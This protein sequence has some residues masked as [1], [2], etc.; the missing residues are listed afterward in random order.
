A[1]LEYAVSV[2]KGRAL[3]EVCDGQ[4][5]V[6]RRILY[7]MHEMGLGPNTKPVKSARV[8]GDVI[9]KFHPHGDTAAYE[10]MVRMAQDFVMRYPLV[11]G[12]G[13][14]GS[15][16]GDGA[17]AM[18]YTEARLTPLA[19]L[20]LSEI[21]KGTVDFIANYDG[22][23]QEPKMLPSRLP[24]VLLN[25]ASGIAVGMAT[26]IPSHNL[27]EI[28]SA[29]VALIRN[30]EMTVAELMEHVPGP[31][32]PGGAQII[33]S[34][35]EIQQAYETG[36]S[37]LKVRARW[38]V[39]ELARGQWQVVVTELPPNTSAAHVLEEIEEL[40]NPKVKAGKKTLTHDQNQTK[41]LI[42]DVLDTAR[43]ESGKDTP[44]RL[45]FEPKSSRKDRNEF[46]TTLLAHTS[47][48][49]SVP[50]NMVMIGL[51]GRPRQK[52]LKDV[53]T[54]WID[55]RFETV[56]RRSQH[57]LNQVLDRIHVLE[58][59]QIVF[60]N[61]DAVIK[62]IREADDPKADLMAKFK[63]SE[64]QAEDILEIRLR[65]L[66]RLEGIKIE[67]ELSELRGEQSELELLLASPQALQAQVVKEIKADAKQF[68]DD[69]RTL[70]EETQRAVLTVNVVNEPLTIVLSDKGWIR[71]R[72]GHSLDLS[73]LSFKEGD[74]LSTSMEC[75]SV[76]NCIVFASDGRVYSIPAGQIPG[77]RGDGVPVTTFIELQPKARI[78]QMV[79]GRAEQAL[80]LATSGGYGFMCKLG[81]LTSRNRAGKQF[82]TVEEGETVLKPVLYTEDPEL[83]LAAVS[84]HGRMHCFPLN[85]MKALSGGGRGVIV[86][87]LDDHEAMVALTTYKTAV[88]V[89]GAIGRSTKPFVIRLEGAK[90][91]DY[92]GKRARKGRLIDARLKLVALLG[93]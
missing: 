71:S 81:D 37:S 88:E 11:D 75:R 74:Q 58:G 82:I 14:F 6:Q 3:P 8:V 62:T 21:D 16:D 23:Q 61:L 20:L 89:H 53:L 65:Q 51:D 54:E 45:V 33:S 86:M 87:G 29:A 25:G 34:P 91:V 84:E 17:A 67:Q 48:E 27:R 38:K 68:G 18:R 39:E 22:S 66:A 28:A 60:L 52:P 79:A 35:A 46:I 50:I 24:M 90:L 12:Q 36:R 73:Q 15:R 63:L 49:T 31:D 70:I 5:P 44:V 47:L 41:A 92:V 57:R 42:L 69:R 55:F 85:E 64:R 32:F 93:F 10:A 77:G 4:K 76:D 1:Y 9:G 13:N 80:L 30:R 72:Q 7:A 59:R 56:R 43:D 26:E 2:V 83:M 19:S 40:T 78:V